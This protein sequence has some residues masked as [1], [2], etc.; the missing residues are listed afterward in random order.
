MFLYILLLLNYL[1]NE[2]LEIW[3]FLLKTCA[4]EWNPDVCFYFVNRDIFGMNRHNGFQRQAA[5]E[6]WRTIGQ[7][8]FSTVLLLF[9]EYITHTY[10]I[11]FMIVVVLTRWTTEL[12]R[13][14][15]L[16][17]CYLSIC[18]N[19]VS[20]WNTLIMILYNV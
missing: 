18:N 8:S 2:I 15:I 5:M 10:S 14:N 1:S 13:K 7:I 4:I 16:R 11:F 17:H 20:L 12:N 9:V 19:C 3:S 6:V